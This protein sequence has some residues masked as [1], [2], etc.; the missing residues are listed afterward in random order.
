METIIIIRHSSYTAVN[1]LHCNAFQNYIKIAFYAWK[2]KNLEETYKIPNF[3]T[4]PN[5]KL[6]YNDTI[7]Y[8]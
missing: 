8:N 5:V 7:G 6:S 4:R 2:K 1:A 3:C